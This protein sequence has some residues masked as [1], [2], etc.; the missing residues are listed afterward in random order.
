MSSSVKAWPLASRTRSALGQTA[1]GQWDV[2][3]DDDVTRSGLLGDPVVG[4]AEAG[5]HDHLHEGVGRNMERGVRHDR[6]AHRIAA[7]NA[8]HLVLDRAS[9]GVDV[10]DQHVSHPRSKRCRAARPLMAPQRQ[11]L[12]GDEFD[13]SPVCFLGQQMFGLGQQAA[14]QSFGS[15]LAGP[16]HGQLSDVALIAHRPA[17][18]VV[19]GVPRL[20]RDAAQSDEHLAFQPVLRRPK[21]ALAELAVA[22]VLAI[23]QHAD[24]LHRPAQNQSHH[25]VAGFVVSSGG[26]VGRFHDFS[27]PGRHGLTK[28]RRLTWRILQ[29][30][31]MRTALA[32][33]T[34]FWEQ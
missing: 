23:R 14:L 11:Q 26:I 12:R 29:T 30:A 4:R 5:P 19:A 8:I 22:Q 3:G 9:V 34:P 15:S 25:R 6:D 24:A 10:E 7:G 18:G 21:H 2:G 20:G 16:L 13:R 27:V 32:A 31:G 17:P 28:L 1:G 33:A